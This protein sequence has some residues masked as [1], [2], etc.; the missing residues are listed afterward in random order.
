MKIINMLEGGRKFIAEGC[1]DRPK[2]DFE[3]ICL[4]IIYVNDFNA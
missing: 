4:P 3:P 2:V 1:Y